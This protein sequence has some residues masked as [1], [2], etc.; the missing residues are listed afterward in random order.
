M[1]QFDTDNGIIFLL[2]SN[3]ALVQIFPLHEDNVMA[4]KLTILL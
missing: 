4:T 3:L 2:Y 1:G